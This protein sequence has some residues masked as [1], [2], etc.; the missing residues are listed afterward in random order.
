MTN[1][2]IAAAYAVERTAVRAT[3]FVACVVFT[4]L[5]LYR[6]STISPKPCNHDFAVYAHEVHAKARLC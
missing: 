5:I 6:F 1:N 4:C 2:K 3:S